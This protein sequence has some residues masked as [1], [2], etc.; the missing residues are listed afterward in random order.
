MVK[1]LWL[2]CSGLEKLFI[3]SLL[4]ALFGCQAKL[5]YR[6]VPNGINITTPEGTPGI[7]IYRGADS[8]FDLYQA[9]TIC[10]TKN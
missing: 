2:K 4:P 5:N 3:I 6:Q 9:L 1:R 8:Q 7:R 10:G